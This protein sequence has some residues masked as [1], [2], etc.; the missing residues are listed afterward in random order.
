MRKR[1]LGSY[2]EVNLFQINPKNKYQKKSLEKII[3][4]LKSGKI[5]TYMFYSPQVRTGKTYFMAGLFNYLFNYT[6]DLLWKADKELK[7]DFL[8][9]EMEEIEYHIVDYI[10]GD[11]VPKLYA[12]FWD[13]IGKATVSDY[14]LQEI[15]YMLDEMIKRETKLYLTSIID[16]SEIGNVYGISIARRIEDLIDEILY[17][18]EEMLMD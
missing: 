10:K 13:D 6:Q 14:V 4:D 3:G 18:G 15:F 9:Y 5:K 12:L 1:I 11:R 16:L 7:E 17:F 8:R 2:S